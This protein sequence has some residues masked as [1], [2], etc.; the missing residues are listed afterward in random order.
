MYIAAYM[1][2]ER[3]DSE[4]ADSA[5]CPSPALLPTH[6]AGRVLFAVIAYPGNGC[7]LELRQAGAPGQ[8]FGA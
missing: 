6:L 8:Q 3:R 5:G 1:D 4:S 7:W 2:S